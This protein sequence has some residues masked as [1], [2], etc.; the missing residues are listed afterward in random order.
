MNARRISALPRP[1]DEVTLGD[2]ALRAELLEAAEVLFLRNG[3]AHT[4]IEAIVRD[5][6]TSKREYYRYFADKESIFLQVVDR[7][8]RGNSS[9]ASIP[10][11]D[12][13]EVLV[14]VAEMTLTG[15]LHDRSLGLYRASIAATMLSPGLAPTVYKSR[16]RN[17]EALAQYLARCRRTHAL[18]FDDPFLAALRF[19]FL[20]IDGMRY[21][22][23]APPP[24]KARQK[25]LAATVALL[26]LDGH[27]TAQFRRRSDPVRARLQGVLELGSGGATPEPIPPTPSRLDESVWSAFHDTAWSTFLQQGYADTSISAIGRKIGIARSTIYRRY[28]DKEALF[29]VIATRLIDRCFDLRF[30]I[31]WHRSSI[32]AALR[33]VCGAVLDRYLQT[34][35][36]NLQ[37]ILLVAA[38]SDRAVSHRIYE[39]MIARVVAVFEPLLRQLADAGVIVKDDINHASRRLFVLT[40]FGGRFFYVTPR[41]RHERNVLVREAVDL[42]LYG[43][44]RP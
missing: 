37:K 35:N 14:G 22:M 34:D 21:S 26:F 29:T 24:T 17:A 44:R 38:G 2:S 4:S 15:S 27:V 20:A 13:A 39:H 41:N 31:D 32:E 40:T 28:P 18:A 3:F 36:L 43:C 11:G 7:L 23:G 1:A 12:L 16:A 5:A 6:R 33:H 10:D 9:I 19:G 30:T 42:F 8:L 25:Q